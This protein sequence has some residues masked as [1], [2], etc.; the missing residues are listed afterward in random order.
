MLA[1]CCYWHNVHGVAVSL[2]D[3]L[4]E[5]YAAGH[6]TVN[7]IHGRCETRLAAN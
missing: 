3:P 7:K 1:V 2:S 6:D 5:M 4:I